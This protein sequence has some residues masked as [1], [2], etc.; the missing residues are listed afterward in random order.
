MRAWSLKGRAV[1]GFALAFGVLVAAMLIVTRST[2]RLIVGSQS[3]ANIQEVLTELQTARTLLQ[4]SESDLRGAFLTAEP[5]FLESYATVVRRV[6]PQ[7]VH[8]ASLTAAEPKQLARVQRL[9]T[10]INEKLDWNARTIARLGESGPDAAR[11]MLLSAKASRLSSEIQRELNGMEQEEQQLFALRTTEAESHIRSTLL[12]LAAGAL[13]QFGLL[14]AVYYA[15][16]RDAADRVRNAE[17]MRQQLVF[18]AAITDN[19]GEGIYA[20]DREGRLTFMNPAAQ[21]MLGWKE[22]DLL[23]NDMHGAIHFQTLD[24][25][26]VPAS[27]CPLLGVLRSGEKF[28]STD[29]VFTRRDGTVFPVEYVSSPFRR[30]GGIVG[31]VV[32]FR[33]IGVRKRT[34]AELL[35]RANQGLF[36]ADVGAALTKAESLPTA[37]RQCTDAMVRHLGAA[38]AS[39]WTLGEGEKIL[40]LQ[41]SA[42]AHRPLFGPDARV[43]VG[44][45]RIGEIARDRRPALL[46]LTAGQEREDDK[47][48]ARREGMVAFA[49]YPLI[50]EGRLVGVMAMFATRPLTETTLPALA[51]VADEIAL[52]ID[53]ARASEA[54]RQSESRT[55]AVVE[56]MMEALIIADEKSLIRAMNPAAERIFGYKAEELVGRP[57]ALLVPESVAP[58]PLPSLREAHRRALGRVTEWEGRRKNGEVFPFDLS[59]FEFRTAEGRRFGGSIRDI[60][61]R[62]E[63]ERLKKEFVSTVSHELRTPLTSIRGSLGL[64]AGGVLGELP[65][66]AAEVIAVAERN[67]LR[68]VRLI[69]DIL[70]LERFDSGR[71]EMNLE[72]VPLDSV[73]ARSLEAVRPF[74]D[75]EGV[76]LETSPA[77]AQICADGDRLVQVLVNLLSNAV[78][79]SPRGSAVRLSASQED[80]WSQVRVRDQG[81]GIPASLREAIFERFRQV[82]ASDARQKGGS[83]LGLAICKAII[84][85]HGGSIGVESEEGKGSV[86]WFRLPDSPRAQERSPLLPGGEAASSAGQPEVLIV[87]DDL[88]LLDI[89]ERQ[90]LEAGLRVRRATTGEQ[91]IALTRVRPPSL[92]VLDVS[93]PRGDGFEVVEALRGEPSLAGLPVLVYTVHDLT[94]QERERLKLGPTR[95]LTKTRSTDADFCA[96][97]REMI[98]Q[99]ASL[100]GEA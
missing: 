5:K 31:A 57:L 45:F 39:I 86:F 97:V 64:L 49:G 18:T 11:A 17:R 7:I 41:G 32:A 53:R 9:E 70:D 27:E 42:W 98:G 73:F 93:L 48:W 22:E 69:N 96:V 92:I 59:L 82:E 68:L 13:L 88:A 20:L 15:M 91:A 80:G 61:E 72:T 6:H 54:L 87:E 85:Q 77:A 79:F 21:A 74:A 33:D 38:M 25:R 30:D 19:L 94:S 12:V 3:V 56:N 66:Q 34:E 90:L 36:A 89:L 50:V 78:K 99:T 37:L 26:A 40:E 100:V 28:H 35:E 16:S 63:V 81:R 43:P 47:D 83:G 84:E 60:S 4:E 29:D 46:D 23:G 76:T 67:V 52:G 2:Q 65:P 62:R 44:E 58:N 75:Q 71:L 24:G 8:I 10:R 1:L 55:R 95:F 51:S 14:F